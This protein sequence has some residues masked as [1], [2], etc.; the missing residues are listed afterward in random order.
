M[1]QVRVQWVVI[2]AWADAVETVKEHVSLVVAEVAKALAQ[3]LVTTLA[4]AVATVSN[5]I[6]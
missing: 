5:L 1:L 2:L 6:I 4:K 3:H